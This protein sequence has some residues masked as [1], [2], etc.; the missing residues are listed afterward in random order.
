MI[1]KDTPP[2]VAA[3]PAFEVRQDD[4]RS[5]DEVDHDAYVAAIIHA[6]NPPDDDASQVSVLLAAIDQ[7]FAFIVG[8]PCTCPVGTVGT[9]IDRFDSTI[10]DYYGL[11]C[12]RCQALGRSNDKRIER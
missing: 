5:D 12:R 3:D 6:F 1:D 9:D 8:Q 10:T 11:W 2:S 4:Q 7:A